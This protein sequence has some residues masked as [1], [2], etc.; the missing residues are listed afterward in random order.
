MDYIRAVATAPAGWRHFGIDALERLPQAVRAH[1]LAALPPDEIHLVESRDQG[2]V[3]RVL[4][5]LFWTLVY[6]LEADRWDQLARIEPIHPGIIAA[7][8]GSV[9]TSLDVGAGSGRL[10]Q[11]LAPRS[12]RLVAIEP[13]AGLG[14]ILHSRLP[15]V[16][17]VAGWAEA[18][19]IP[20]GWSSLTAACG[21]FGPEPAI[22]RELRRVTRPGGVILLISPEE[23]DWFE[24]NG[25]WRQTMAPIPALDREAWIDDFFGPPDP[26]HEVVMTQ[27]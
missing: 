25:W 3:E 5:A 26:P 14:S 16:G 7:L 24:A 10:T 6:H 13:S 21:A 17:V 18:L 22:L 8:P 20:D 9:E 12:R 4:R 1:A 27:V 15:E 2:A 11:H 23:P 19:P